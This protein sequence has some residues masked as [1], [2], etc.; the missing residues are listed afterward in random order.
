MSAFKEDLIV[1]CD[2]IKFFSKENKIFSIGNSHVR[3]SS[4]DLK[5]DSI[6]VYTKIDS[7]IAHGNTIL[8]Q[9]NQTITANRIEY[10]KIKD[11]D[12][13]SFTSIGNVTIKDSLRTATCGRARY[14]RQKENT[15]LEIDPQIKD[16]SKRTLSGK[17]I[18]ADGLYFIGPE[19]PSEFKIKKP[20]LKYQILPT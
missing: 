14:N 11:S 2:T 18:S 8:V 12:G 20:P 13:V 4:Y 7:G 6:T 16:K 1:T 9:K 5:A 19:Y 3:N 10:Q 17:T 15:E